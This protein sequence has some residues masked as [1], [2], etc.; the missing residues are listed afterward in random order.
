M[1]RF[2]DPCGTFSNG[3]VITELSNYPGAKCHFVIDRALVCGH[4][5]K[6][7]FT[8]GANHEQQMLCPTHARFLARQ[9]VPITLEPYIGE[10]R[11]PIVEHV[12]DQEEGPFFSN[13]P[14]P[15]ME[16]RGIQETTAFDGGESGGGG[17]GASFDDTFDGGDSGGAGSDA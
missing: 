7:E 14:V 8:D 17:G 13:G 12:T 16:E 2:E 4:K 11:R 3:D 1:T 9:R 5:A 15:V 6:Y 10:T